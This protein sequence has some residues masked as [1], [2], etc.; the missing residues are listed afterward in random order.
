MGTQLTA[1]VYLPKTVDLLIFCDKVRWK[2]VTNFSEDRLLRR[3]ALQS[4]S[5]LFSNTKINL[6]KS[7]WR[8]NHHKLYTRVLRLE[9]LWIYKVYGISA[10]KDKTFESEDEESRYI[11]N[12]TAQFLFGF[13]VEFTVDDRLAHFLN[14]NK[15]IKFSKF[16]ILMRKYCR[17]LCFKHFFINFF[18]QNSNEY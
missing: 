16:H 8:F 5:F 7:Y 15:Y 4:C 14:L 10:Y 3:L 17:L 2:Q 13:P 11:L 1:V 18:R 12:S 9:P 6:I